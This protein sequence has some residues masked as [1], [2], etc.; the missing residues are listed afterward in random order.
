VLVSPSHGGNVGAAARAMRVMGLRTLF[1]AALLRGHLSHPDAIVSSGANDILA[2]ATEVDTL[3]EALAG[4]RRGR[5]Q[6]RKPSSAPHRA[7]VVGVPE[8]VAELAA[9]PARQVA[10]VFGPE[11]TGLS[12][13]HVSAALVWSRFRANPITTR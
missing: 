6:R 3:E 9:D 8:I 2:A 12:I 4:V 13:E 11:R 10:L 1:V 5:G 7:A